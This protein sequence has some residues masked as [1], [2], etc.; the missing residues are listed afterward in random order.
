MW[1]YRLILLIA[2]SGLGVSCGNSDPVKIGYV[3]AI[4][5]R[6]SQL[7]INGRNGVEMAAREWNENGGVNG[8]TVEIVVRDDESDSEIGVTIVNELVRDVGVDVVVGPLTS[9]MLPAV[10]AVRDAGVLVFSPIMSTGQLTG[11][12][13]HFVR[14][15]LTLKHQATTLA[16]KMDRDG[17]SRTSIVFD[18]SNPQ[19]TEEL[20]THFRSEFRARNGS[21]TMS[22]PF[23]SAANPDYVHI[24]DEIGEDQSPAVVFVT[25][26]IDAG[27]LAQQLWKR[28]IEKALYGA[29]W[30]KTTGRRNG[31]GKPVFPG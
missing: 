16:E 2:I 1:I 25:T 19:Y 26:G 13:D 22:Y 20:V 18:I 8:R 6:L 7:G 30:A 10:Q 28:N 23:S 3:A 27:V 21:V 4:T 11:L 14:A 9:N 12:D 31:L 29:E 15:N 5:G 17:I 24:A